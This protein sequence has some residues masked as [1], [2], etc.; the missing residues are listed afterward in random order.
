MIGSH[1]GLDDMTLLNRLFR[2]ESPKFEHPIKTTVGRVMQKSGRFEHLR[3]QRVGYELPFFSASNFSLTYWVEPG[4]VDPTEEFVRT[5]LRPG[6]VFVDVGANVGTVSALAAGVVG[7]N[8]RVV[9]IEPHPTTFS[10]LRRTLAANGRQNVTCLNVACG[11]T[12]GM[13][14]LTDEP[15]KDDNNKVDESGAGIPVKVTALIDLLRDHS[16]AKVDLLKI[17]VEGFEYAVLSGL[18]GDLSMIGAMHIEVIEANLGRYGHSTAAIVSLLQ[19]NGFAC[20]EIIDDPTNL[21]AFSTA[22]Q[23][24]GWGVGLV[25][26]PGN[27]VLD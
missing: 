13:A 1:G 5:V 3:V 7:P 11:S 19:R 18:E 10:L 17:D 12:A 22:P 27:P 20:F 15:R 23:V 26:L 4:L 21:V 6:D 8:G 9:A 25:G 16:L 2:S 24:S 14:T